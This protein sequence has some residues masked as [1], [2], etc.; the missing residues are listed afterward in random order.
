M[1]Q[2]ASDDPVNASHPIMMDTSE[3]IKECDSVIVSIPTPKDTTKN[4]VHQ[5]LPN[6][7]ETLNGASH[8]GV[9]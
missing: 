3:D 8:E 6:D 7:A 5:Q 2:V 1:L 4:A 9:M